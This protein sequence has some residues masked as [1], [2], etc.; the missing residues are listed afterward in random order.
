M[1]I[2]TLQERWKPDTHISFLPTDEYTL[3][4][5]DVYMLLDLPID[6]KADNGIINLINLIWRNF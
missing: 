4:L 6:G 2:L 1:F 3:P 5:E